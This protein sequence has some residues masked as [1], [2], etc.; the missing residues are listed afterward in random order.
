MKCGF[1]CTSV[2]TGFAPL[3]SAE[4]T[5]L[6]ESCPSNYEEGFCQSWDEEPQQ[7]L[8]S[9]SHHVATRNLDLEDE[10][11]PV[12]NKENKQV[13][14]R[15]DEGIYETEALENSKFN[16]D[17]GYSSMLSNQYAD[18]IEH[19]DSIPLAGNLCGTPK[20]CLMKNQNQAQFSKKTLLPVIHYEEMI[21]STLKKSGKRNLKSWAA[22]DRIVFRGN[23]ELCN[24]IG[25]KM[26][27]DK[28]DFLAELFK[29]NLKHILANILKH[30]GEMDL[31][32]FAKVSTTWRKILQEDKWS[33]EIYNRAMENLSNGTKASEQAATREYVLYRTALSSIQKAAPP[34]N[35][36]K[37]GTRSKASKNHS[38][39]M[40]FSEA[41]KTLRNT[42]SLKV[43]H[44]CGSPAKYDS[45]LQRAMCN[46]ESCGFDFCTR[47]LCSYHSSSVCMSGKS[48]KPRSKL[49]PL[50]GTK[51]SKQNLQRL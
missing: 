31:I 20:H 38:R 2:C 13:I 50:P 4:K 16:E 3:K 32:N 14:Q 44:R 33:L 10:G 25:K 26:G 8:L 23:V 29:K 22:V 46:R 40:E 12:H 51:K 36:T 17:S 27:L 18:A 15:L 5:R 42:E 9:D 19:E 41:A 39:L 34:N 35:L 11:R 28:I 6:E 43:C 49:E 45:Y 21:C 47:C 7:I 48:V 1:D 24:L 37:K 30:L